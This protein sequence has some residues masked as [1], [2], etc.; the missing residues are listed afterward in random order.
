M[1]LLLLILAGV[2]VVAAGVLV[3]VFR[4][5]RYALLAV[6]MAVLLLGAALGVV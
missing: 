4:L 1:L 2:L 3:F 6:I 5:L